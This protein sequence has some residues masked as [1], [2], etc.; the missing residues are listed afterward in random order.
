MKKW[1]EGKIETTTGE[2]EIRTTT[3]KGGG[4]KMMTGE[5]SD[6]TTMTDDTGGAVA[7]RGARTDTGE[8]LHL[9]TIGTEDAAETETTAP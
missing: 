1:I 3:G 6:V 9:P 2:G 4:I 5:G 8:A 7:Q